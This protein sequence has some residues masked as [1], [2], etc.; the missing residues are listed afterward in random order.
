M[1]SLR[2]RLHFLLPLISGLALLWALPSWK[3]LTQ[4]EHT[5][6]LFTERFNPHY[7]LPERGTLNH[8]QITPLRFIH[9][10]TE[11]PLATYLIDDETLNIIDLSPE[12]W[13][14][15]LQTIRKNTDDLL[16]ITA[17]LSWTQA[18]ELSLQTL[19][20]QITKTPQLVLGL[21]AEFNNTS[22]PLP[23]FLKNSII[24]SHSSDLP[25]L[26]EID[27]LP[28]PPSVNPPLF[29]ISTIQDLIIEEN[30]TQLK[31][32]MLVRWDGAI[33]PSIHLAALIA[34]QKI[35]PR[36]V[37]INPS[38]YLRL[39]QNGPIIRIDSQGRCTLPNS[40]NSTH[41]ASQLLLT[42]QQ[43]RSSKIILPANAPKQHQLLQTHLSQHLSQKPKPLPSYTRWP[44]PIEIIA[45][46]L[47]TLILQAR[48]LWF[49]LLALTTLLLSP[50]L[51]H[52][53][54]FT[55]LA[56]TLCCSLILPKPKN[57]NTNSPPAKKPNQTTFS[58]KSPSPT[59]KTPQKK[60]RKQGKRKK[61]KR[62]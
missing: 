49:T 18:S 62:R 13:A 19:D 21:D 37:I 26:P 27:F 40:G 39:G 4:L 36:E 1:T 48:R 30:A 57:R 2:P 16:V 20:H 25:Q 6:F 10:I 17:P 42:S 38:G 46:T 31:I 56:L 53:F 47:F 7:I 41:S 9:G 23:P 50:T 8:F 51:Q 35:A 15:L 33:L 22:A 5:L 52:W 12:K 59:K 45:L 14:Y 11:Q 44:L 32:P 55:P 58:K 3:P 29:G 43:S 24:S 34:S 28:Q 61:K 54:P 60:P